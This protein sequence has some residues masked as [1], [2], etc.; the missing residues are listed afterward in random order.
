MTNYREIDNRLEEVTETLSK[1]LVNV[2]VLK[3]M[4]AY[5]K[6]EEGKK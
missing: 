5:L 2:I 1:L 6:Q 3:S 4:V